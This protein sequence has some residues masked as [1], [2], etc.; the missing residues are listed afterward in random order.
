MFPTEFSVKER[1][2]LWVRFFSVFDKVEVKAL[3]KILEQK[4]RCDNCLVSIRQLHLTFDRSTLF[5]FY[6]FLM[7]CAL[8]FRGFL[9]G[10][11]VTTRDAEVSITQTDASGLQILEIE[12]LNLELKG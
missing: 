1:V 3:E 2:K 7:D 4:Q 12:L 10:L 9:L 11:Q 8:I 5:Q 6:V